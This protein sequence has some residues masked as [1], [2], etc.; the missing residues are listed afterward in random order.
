MFDK[1]KNIALFDESVINTHR[2]TLQTLQKELLWFAKFAQHLIKS[3]VGNMFDPY[4]VSLQTKIRV[5]FEL[6]SMVGYISREIS[7]FVYGMDF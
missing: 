7:S 5:K 1:E 2:Q 4:S 3:E 6:T